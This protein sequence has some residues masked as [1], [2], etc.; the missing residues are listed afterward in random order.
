MYIVYIVGKLFWVKISLIP[1][2]SKLMIRIP[3]IS[4]NPIESM[5]QPLRRS[6]NKEE[7][8]LMF[9]NGVDDLFKHIHIASNPTYWSTPSVCPAIF[10]S[11]FPQKNMPCHIWHI[12]HCFRILAILSTNINISGSFSSWKSSW[13]PGL[14][15][16]TQYEFLKKKPLQSGVAHQSPVGRNCY[17]LGDPNKPLELVWEK[18][19]VQALARPSM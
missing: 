14:L 19:E 8:W 15:G 3:V 1:W 2:K 16:K 18:A 6:N 9:F 17:Q 12:I 13:I 5:R 10:L 7:T 4:Y 11:S